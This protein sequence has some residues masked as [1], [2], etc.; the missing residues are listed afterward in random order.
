MEEYKDEEFNEEQVE[1]E[2]EVTEDYLGSA[3]DLN[4]FFR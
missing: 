1:D 2:F 4:F 3:D